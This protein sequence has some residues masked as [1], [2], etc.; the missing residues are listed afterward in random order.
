ML[1]SERVFHLTS[2]IH[3]KIEQLEQ[4]KLMIELQKKVA[5]DPELMIFSA[6]E[7]AKDS[8]KR[9]TFNFKNNR[10]QEND[11]ASAAMTSYFVKEGII[12]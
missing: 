5:E 1:R 4:E 2:L 3:Q 10:L 11:M 6:L 12:K 8:C 9:L 7:K